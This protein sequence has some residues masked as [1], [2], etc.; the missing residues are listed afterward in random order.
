M[1]K[2]SH[3]RCC[4]W[5]ETARMGGLKTGTI[6][7][8][9]IA[10]AEAGA[11]LAGATGSATSR[12][13]SK[14]TEAGSA[15]ADKASALPSSFPEGLALSVLATAASADPETAAGS[16]TLAAVGILYAEKTGNWNNS[17]ATA[18]NIQPPQCARA[19]REEQTRTA[20]EAE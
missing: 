16:L 1:L 20:Q 18:S 2:A 10:T 17:A 19:F 12:P 11:E 15:S 4:R 13:G 7:A 6:G 9:S 14:L 8:G 5:S 3:S